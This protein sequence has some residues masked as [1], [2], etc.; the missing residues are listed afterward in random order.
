MPKILM[1]RSRRQRAAFVYVYVP[2]VLGSR[3]RK[4]NSSKNRAVEEG[5]N[6]E[7]SWKHN[8][9]E[10]GILYHKWQALQNHF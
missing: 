4:K 8:D 3:E 7:K 5:E 10:A 2:G 9:G 1:P 6:M